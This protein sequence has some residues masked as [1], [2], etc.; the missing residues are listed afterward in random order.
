[1]WKIVGGG[2]RVSQIGLRED[3]LA[4]RVRDQQGQVAVDGKGMNLD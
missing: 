4:A 3:I 2:E 1:M